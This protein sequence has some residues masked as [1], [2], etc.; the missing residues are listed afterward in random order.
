[1]GKERIKQ[2][3]NRRLIKV[4]FILGHDAGQLGFLENMQYFFYLACHQ[5]SLEKPYRSL[6]SDARGRGTGVVG[7]RQGL[8]GS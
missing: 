3:S 7:F 1:M 6:N 4:S 2:R 5:L 8:K